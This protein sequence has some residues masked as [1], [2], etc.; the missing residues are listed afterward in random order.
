M[1]G[2]AGISWTAVLNTERRRSSVAPQATDAIP[3]AADIKRDALS[4]VEVGSTVLV[5]VRTCRSSLGSVLG[6]TALISAG[7]SASASR[8][9]SRGIGTVWQRFDLELNRR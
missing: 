7:A 6:A 9:Q 1:Y 3:S 4:I 2:A 8:Q 5:Q